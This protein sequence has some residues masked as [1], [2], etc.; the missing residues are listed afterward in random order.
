MS[1]WQ[2]VLSDLTALRDA[3]PTPPWS[4]DARF[5][6]VAA[7]FSSD[8]EADARAA[9]MR[10]FPRGWTQKSLDTAPPPYLEIATRT[11]GLRASQRLLGGRPDHPGTLYALWWPW[12]GGAT[13][14]L[15]I[16]LADQAIPDA[17]PDPVAELRALFGV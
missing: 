13:T 5:A 1:P 8:R 9:A 6:T 16:G 12:S 11:G 10:A 15:R 17:T 2:L 4:W 7:S 14:T 3:W